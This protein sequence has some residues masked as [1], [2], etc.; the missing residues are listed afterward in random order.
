MYP[1]SAIL[2]SLIYI[3]HF[4]S[5]H[6]STSQRLHGLSFSPFC[7]IYNILK[8]S[9]CI[10]YVIILPF[11]IIE[12]TLSWPFKLSWFSNLKTQDY[13]FITQM[14]VLFS[15]RYIVKRRVMW[16]ISHGL[17]YTKWGIKFRF[18]LSSLSTI[19]QFLVFKVFVFVFIFSPN[20]LLIF[21]SWIPFLK[22]KH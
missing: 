9:K 13:R 22:K 4:H 1:M 16:L 11:I 2:K 19:T 8:I 17:L 6:V 10:Y 21:C 5:P 14:F 3:T 12:L 7:M 15:K 20:T 18:P